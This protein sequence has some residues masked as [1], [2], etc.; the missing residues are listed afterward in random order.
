MDDRDRI[1]ELE[2]RVAELAALV[3]RMSQH[4]LAESA[5]SVPAPSTATVDN[6]ASRRNVLKLAGAAAAGAVVA[7]GSSAMPAAADDPNDLTLGTAKATAGLTR[8]DLNTGAPGGGLRT[9]FF[10]QVGQAANQVNFDQLPVSS[11][12]AGRT[13]TSDAPTG[14]FG[15]TNQAFGFGVAG[16]NTDPLGTG[17]NGIGTTGVNG[18][19]TA[20]GVQGSS[21]TGTGLRAAGATGV[22]AVGSATGVNG[23]VTTAAGIGVIG[24]GGD[25][26]IGVRGVGGDYAIVSAKSNKA[27]LLLAPSND[28]ATPGTKVTPS[29]RT[30]AHLVG[31]IDNVGGDLWFCV[32]AGTPGVWR[33][34]AGPTGAGVFHALTPGRVYDSRLA[35]P[36]GSVGNLASGQNRT[37]SVADRRNL[38]SGVVDLADF[39]PAGATA[40]F[41]NV[42]VD[43][44]VGSGFLA[45][46]PGGNTTVSASAINWSAA[47]Q[48]LSNG[49]TLTLSATRHI[50]VIAGGG[51]STQFIVDVTGYYL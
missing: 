25:N 40:V 32:V 44:T 35:Q 12:L 19:G 17:V 36:E 3:E 46:N 8:A 26:G 4:Q 18:T 14:V 24:S 42:T 47:G 50:T 27:N 48:I 20:I 31:E 39:V 6:G 34:L 23:T 2:S 45:I 51:G 33:K 7:I 16:T 38:T 15:V 9:A 21:T 41:A 28:P 11:A 30:D 29:A 49:L 5:R 10:F 37:V 13:S 43:A 22:L 1:N